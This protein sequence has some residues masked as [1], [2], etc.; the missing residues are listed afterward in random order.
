MVL[1]DIIL[2]WSSG[3]VRKY[4]DSDIPDNKVRVANMGPPGSWRP[5]VGPTLAPWILLSGIPVCCT[6]PLSSEG[7][8]AYFV[9]G[10][11]GGY[12]SILLT[13]SELDDDKND[14]IKLFMGA[15]K[16]L[17]VRCG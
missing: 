5:Q 1:K 9:S 10:E 2:K 13:S 14:A 15:L 8:N 11:Y 6:Q 12:I 17:P 4:N 3:S 7:H 16:S